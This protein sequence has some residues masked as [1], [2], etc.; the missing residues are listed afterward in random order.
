[1][2]RIHVDSFTSLNDLKPNDWRD[3]EKV[4]AAALAAGR[5]SVFEA[6]QSD[7]AA[8]QMTTLCRDPDVE[9]DN[10]CGYPWTLVRKRSPK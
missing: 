1:V 3:Y 4:K 6:T 10:T 2:Y 9:I 8:R 7:T 5:F